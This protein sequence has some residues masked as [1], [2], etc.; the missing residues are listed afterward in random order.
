[1]KTKRFYYLECSECKN[2]NYKFK[3]SGEVK[4]RDLKVKKHCGFCKKHTIHVSVD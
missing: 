2:R 3:N 1:M 4:T